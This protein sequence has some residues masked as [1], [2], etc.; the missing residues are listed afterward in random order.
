MEK[1][2]KFISESNIIEV[3]DKLSSSLGD[4]LEIGLKKMGIDE[5]HSVGKH[6]LKWDLFNKNCINSFKEGTLIARYAKRGPWNMVPLVDFSSHFIFS[7]MRE[8]RFIELCRGKGKRKR[9]HYMEA[10][11]QSFNFALGEAS[12]MS[13]FLEDQDRKEEVAQIVDGILKDMQVEKYAIENYAVILFNEYNHELV[14][15]KCCVINSDLQIVDQ[16][17]WSSYI[18]HRQSIVPEVVEGDNDLQYNQSVSLNAK[19]RERA[20]Q[21][22]NVEE[23]KDKKE[24]SKNA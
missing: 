5:R 10:F 14:S 3:V 13:V 9:L 11:A 23:K 20:K 18:K 2:Y 6:Y 8:E 12:Q 21:R 19:A 7:V 17:D 22:T 24:N 15:I 16:E 1:T 4:E